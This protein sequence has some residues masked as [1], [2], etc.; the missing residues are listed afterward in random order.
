MAGAGLMQQRSFFDELRES[1]DVPDVGEVITLRPYQRESVNGV[2]REWESGHVSTLVTLPTGCGKSVVFSAVM[3]EVMRCQPDRRILVLAHREELIL[4]AKQHAENAGLEAGVEMGG[5]RAYREPVVISTVQTQVAFSKCRDCFGEGCDWCGHRGKK[6]R[7]Q[8]FDPNQFSTLIIDEAHHATAE[9]YRIVQ[10]YYR[11]NPSLRVL[12][13]TATPKRTD[14]V[15]LHNVCDS[16]AYEMDMRDAISDGW[17][18]PIRQQFITVDGLDLSRVKSRNGDLADGERERAFLGDTDEVEERMLHAIAYPTIEA[19]AG[20]RTLVFAAGQ[21]HAEKLTAAFNSYDGVEAE[22]VIDKTDRHE[23]RQIIQRF[24]DGLTQVLV[25]CM[26]F[27]E[28]FDVPDAA[29]CANARPTKSTSLYQQM[30]GRVTRP[31]KGVVDFTRTPEGP[32]LAAERRAAIAASAKPSCLVLDFTG[33]SG[34]H[35]LV[36]VADILAGEDVDP[37]D[38][39]AA[40]EAAQESSEPVDVEELIEKAK[41][42]R[43]AAEARREEERKKRLQTQ[44]YATGGDIHATDVDIFGG[45]SFDPFSDYTPAP[46]GAS[47]KQVAFLM[48]LGVKAETATGYSRR[49]A[50]KVI[51]ELTKRTGGEFIV[52]FGKYSGKPLRHIPRGYLRWMAQNLNREDVQKNIALYRE[53]VRQGCS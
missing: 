11:Q 6:R 50:G 30:I 1:A 4:Q 35:K 47:Q 14:N 24:R 45:P 36:S 15:G 40:L 9:S 18:V 32:E 26:V 13:V 43:E 49:Q 34:E 12:L 41:E 48:K 46:N 21:E 38:L 31:M 27:T 28:G 3:D 7:L 2:F 25:N 22:F 51:D 5:Y 52:T 10:E 53:E 16:V 8:R 44:H 39:E 37:V 42:A 33:D 17:L 20:R 23:R 19:A 29:V